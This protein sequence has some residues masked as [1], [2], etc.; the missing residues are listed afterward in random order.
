GR[1]LGDLVDE[2]GPAALLALRQEGREYVALAPLEARRVDRD[3]GAGGAGAHGVEGGGGQPLAPPGLPLDQH[4]ARAVARPLHPAEQLLHGR[5][6]T[7][8]PAQARRLTARAR[9]AGG[10][11]R[12]A[13]GL[14]RGA[15]PLPFQD[16]VRGAR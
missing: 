2:Q 1:Q 8:E 14:A 11:G 7:E 13:G 12:D 5:G 4:R 6:A 16:L 15:A 9:G 10:G 3:E